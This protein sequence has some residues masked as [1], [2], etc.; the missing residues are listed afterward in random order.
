MD[1]YTNT[2]VNF[3]TTQ[4]GYGNESFLVLPP[5]YRNGTNGTLPSVTDYVASPTYDV[6]LLGR[7][8]ANDTDA[9]VTLAYEYS[10]TYGLQ[11]L[12]GSNATNAP[13]RLPDVNCSNVLSSHT[14][15]TSVSAFFDDVQAVLA[16]NPPPSAY[17]S[18]V[19][20]LAA[21]GCVVRCISPKVF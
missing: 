20:N 4:Y 13:P 10:T 1:I 17:S 15:N 16:A 11:V 21:L 9:D 18:A 3:G 19:S 5:G 6:W 14:L 12:N 8:E 7:T 2:L